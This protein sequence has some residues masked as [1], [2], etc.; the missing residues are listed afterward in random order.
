MGKHLINE[1]EQFVGHRPSKKN[2][3]IFSGKS[4]NNCAFQLNYQK[5]IKKYINSDNIH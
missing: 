5:Q 3:N 2:F 4:P 1:I